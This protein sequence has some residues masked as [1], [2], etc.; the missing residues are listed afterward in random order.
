MR[1]PLLWLCLS[2]LPVTLPAQYYGVSEGGGRDWAVGLNLGLNTVQGDVDPD[3]PGYQAGLTLTRRMSPAFDIQFMLQGGRSQGLNLQRRTGIL[4]NSAYFNFEDSTFIYPLDSGVYHNFRMQFY[5][6]S[7]FAKINLNRLGGSGSENWDAF[8]GL[9][10]GLFFYR[11]FVNVYNEAEDATYAYDSITGTSSLDIKA[12]LQAIMDN[13]YE[14]PGQ[15]DFVN[16][17]QLGQYA[18]TTSVSLIGGFR[19]KLSDRLHLGLNGR[20]IFVGDDL[21]DGQQWTEENG[22]SATRDKLGSAFL[23]LDFGL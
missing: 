9:G 14:T 16:G 5:D 19:I 3:G 4:N 23:T 1:A 12:Q 17:N 13:T 11:T 6:G 15:R 18:F 10:L 8:V 21:L 2:L 7:V 20:M 22:L